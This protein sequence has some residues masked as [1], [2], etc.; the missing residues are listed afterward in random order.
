VHLTRF[1]DLP[2][3]LCCTICR[4]PLQERGQSY[5]CPSCQ[6]DFPVVRGVIRFVDRQNY[7][8]NF[9]Y[10]W[11]RFSR[12]QLMPEYSERHFRR[13]T[14]L[15]E[16]D[17]RGKLVLDVGCGMGRFGEVATR[18][19]A[20]VVGVDLSV[21]AE[22]AAI[23]LADRDFV[24]LQADVFT[25]PFAPESFDCIY[26]VGVLHHTPDCE[27]AFKSLLQFLKPG[28]SIA[29]WLYSGY[30]NW[31]RFSDQ[32]RKIT[33][34]VPVRRLHTFLRMAVPSLY[35]LNRGLR[36]IPLI[37]SPL[38]ALVQHVFPVNQNP[39]P[40]IRILDTLD[41]YSPKYQSKH[42]YE[43]VF[44]WFEACGLENSTVG[45]VPI[46]VKGR[47]PFRRT[48][49]E[50]QEPGLHDGV[51]ALTGYD[52]AETAIPVTVNNDFSP[53]K[54]AVRTLRWFPAYAWQR[55]ARHLPHGNAHVM[56]ALVD[57]FE[58]AIVPGAGSARAT[59]SEQMRR[60]EQWCRNYPL[61]FDSL[62][63]ADGRPFVHTYFYPAEQ[64]DQDLLEVLADHCAS[65]W[66][67]LEVHLH[68][69]T[70]APD[71]A[72]NVRRQLSEFRDRLAFKHRALCYL[73]GN[74]PPRYGFVHGNFALANSAAGRHCGVDSEM[75]VLAE[76]GCYGDFTLPPGLYH[77][78]HIAK[79]NSLYEC[80]TPL[81]QPGAHRRGRD[82]HRGRRPTT[83]PLIVEGPLMLSFVRPDGRRAIRVDNGSLT[84]GNPPSLYRFGLWKRAAIAVKGRP[85]WLF[86]KLQCHGMDPRDNEVM[87]GSRISQFLPDLLQNAPPKA[88]T[89]HFVTA[90]E[91]VNVMLA[92]CD[93]REGNP[94]EYRDYRL[95]RTG[96]FPTA[97][98]QHSEATA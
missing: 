96:T 90:R 43:E 12:T 2:S 75:Q 31:Y 76:T 92:A 15:T 91:M 47:K 37:G 42:T 20:R 51:P 79:I 81:A 74:G 16:N 52:A 36:G 64:Y 9:G 73:D 7:A 21:A 17:L 19:G 40:Q 46:S 58:P 95:K 59:R 72:D 23:N 39:N 62:R 13:K 98:Q 25:L 35:W 38:S 41:W 10:Q 6:K 71:T 94:G 82:L 11:Q 30:N 66:G 97:S 65:G 85:D 77:R 24:A 70:Y 4:L 44:R 55:L 60:L 1:P 69:G 33:T 89:I 53:A 48:E 93:G 68:H 29:V 86:I 45:G 3:I 56:I 34:R 57:H 67:E 83:F 27:R 22:V 14:G 61:V 32:Y 18:W 87:L 49:D 28:G 8:E 80:S 88:E 78:A 63:D 54:K 50:S 5:R 26:S 84:G